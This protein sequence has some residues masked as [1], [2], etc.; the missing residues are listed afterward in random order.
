MEDS[1][2]KKTYI[3]P[4][5]EIVMI[6]SKAQMLAG[7]VVQSVSEETP[8]EWGSRSCDSWDED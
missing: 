2:M 3:N 6:T 7:S 1:N 8:G 4:K 5:Q